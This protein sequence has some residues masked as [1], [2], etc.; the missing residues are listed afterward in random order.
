MILWPLKKTEIKV[1]I[2]YARV[3]RPNGTNHGYIDLKECPEAIDLVPEIRDFPEFRNL[4]IVVGG[5]DSRFHTFGCY[6]QCAESQR[7]E[8][9]R[10]F[11]SYL[12]VVFEAL[13]RNSTT[14]EFESLYSRF[15]QFFQCSTDPADSYGVEFS[16]GLTKFHEHADMIGH[17]VA[18]FNFGWG[19]TDADA[20]D[21][22]EQ[23]IRA[24]KQFFV[25]ENHTFT[26]PL[27]GEA[28]V[29]TPG[30][31]RIE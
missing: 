19:D 12:G 29:S 4:V 24:V 1:G 25:R 14:G 3:E 11:K 13:R 2:P 21:Q 15:K 9:R 8:Y 22:W 26:E 17:H 10:R 6:T 28:T 20:R 30:G 7:P 27:P 18:I 16:I 31:R 23:G 5:P